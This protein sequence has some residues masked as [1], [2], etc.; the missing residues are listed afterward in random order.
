LCAVDDF[1]VDRDGEVE[2]L[3]ALQLLGDLARLCGGAA[4]GDH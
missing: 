4:N 1:V 2:Q 3:A